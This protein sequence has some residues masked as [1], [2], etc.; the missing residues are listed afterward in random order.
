MNVTLAGFVS[1]QTISFVVN[2]NHQNYQCMYYVVDDGKACLFLSFKFTW[3]LKFDFLVL[4]RPAS[5][6]CNLK[7]S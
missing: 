7:L 4:F 3:C 2:L 1:L 6:A 5:K